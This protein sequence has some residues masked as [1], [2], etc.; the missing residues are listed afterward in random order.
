MRA[1]VTAPVLRQVPAWAF[2]SILA[3]LLAAGVV[4]GRSGALGV[5]AGPTHDPLQVVPIPG[6]AGP[7]GA[8]GDPLRLLPRL[9][10]PQV[11]HCLLIMVEFTPSDLVSA[12]HGR[13]YY[14]AM[15]FGKGNGSLDDYYREVSYGH[16]GVAG[17]V[18][19]SG[20]YRVPHDHAY[21]GGEDDGEVSH[22]DRDSVYDTDGD[23][24]IRD[25][26][27]GNYNGQPGTFARALA[28]E[29][30]D[31]ADPDVDFAQFDTN[32]DGYVSA[33][34]LHLMIVH[35]GLD[36]GDRTTPEYTIWS[37]RYNIGAWQEHDGVRLTYYTMMAETNG[38]GI[39]AH[40]MGHDLGW[41]DL[42]D[43]DEGTPEEWDDNEWPLWEWCLMSKGDEGGP[44]A[45]TT[46]P[47]HPCGW[48]KMQQG[49]IQPTELTQSRTN[50]PIRAIETS[51]GPEALYKVHLAWHGSAEEYLL[52]ENRYRDS[53]AL[54]DKF[55][56]N[57]LTS[58]TEKDSGLII[59]H[60]DESQPDG[61]GRWNDGPPRN[62]AYGVWLLD[63]A[64]RPQPDAQETRLLG[65]EY[66]WGGDAAYALEDSGQTEVSDDSPY[67]VYNRL[68]PTTRTNAGA[69]TGIAIRV[70]SPAGQTMTFEIQFGAA[71]IF[72]RDFAPGLHLL[73]L[74]CDP[75]GADLTAVYGTDDI[76]AW[77]PSRNPPR[78]V[79]A[80]QEPG[81]AVLSADPGRAHWVRFGA[82]RHLEVSGR[83]GSTTALALRDG[84]NQI[85]IPFTEPLP[86]SAVTTTPADGL[87]PFA[88]S[89]EGADGYR[90][91]C[92]E[93][94][95]NAAR[96]LEPWRGYWVHANEDCT[97]T[98]PDPSTVAR[99]SRQPRRA[100][101][102]GWAM[103]LVARC[104]GLSDSDNFLGVT[105]AG[106][107][108]RIPSPPAY[109]PRVDL[110]FPGPDG[111]R[112]AADMRGRARTGDTWR[113][114]V[115]TDR[116]DAP[117]TIVWP[118]LAEVPRDL[119][120]VLT[121]LASGETVW[122]RTCPDYSFVAQDLAP[123]LFEIELQPASSALRL[124]TSATVV[125]SGNGAAINYS[126]GRAA[127]IEIEVL[128][129][130]GRVVRRLQS[131]MVSRG[132]QQTFWDGRSAAGSLV[133]NGTYL[134]RLRARSAD[135]AQVVRVLAATL[136]R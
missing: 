117:V 10:T 98:L 95:L 26:A 28:A 80:G 78:Y 99:E 136:L 52:I 37:H 35:S 104:E 82:S 123:R 6:Y 66:Q 118:S 49:W 125:P 20:W 70:T 30:M 11:H 5:R 46:V 57:P 19:G 2:L 18:A 47:A 88:W 43:T 9:R 58:R 107:A 115:T 21:Y 54:F 83:T 103:R 23:G 128:N 89:Y 14:Q 131:R 120:P 53:S 110:F 122:M 16:V 86:W 64:I 38:V 108:L 33:S 15:L 61:A 3:I 45:D 113:F 55:E 129:I 1:L 56:Q 94:S 96:E 65:P 63:A 31:L 100:L 60:V 72:S 90:L 133:P 59:T 34:E 124:L 48:A 50:V 44:N 84:W 106:G 25:D 135:G 12:S 41:P 114:A 85:G 127:S 7:Y 62:S 13:A 75:I 119:A 112:W 51:N 17:T 105:A 67:Y 79:L 39:F 27:G 29:A 77:D 68:F 91:V 4:D 101:P 97:I 40:E 121:D 42:Y 111:E 73:S 132:P 8:N 92:A 22:G 93:P 81:A 134:F 109:G 116:P 36:Q 24:V 32:R 71:R 74:P 126:P 76:A 130:A 69:P 102:A 87:L